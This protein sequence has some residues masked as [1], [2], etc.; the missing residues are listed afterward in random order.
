MGTSTLALGS[1]T[2]T[3]SYQENATAAGFNNTLT[4]ILSPGVYSGGGLSFVGN[5]VSLGAYDALFLSGNQTVSIHTNST[6]DLS[7]AQPTGGGLGAISSGAPYILMTFTAQTFAGNYPEYSFSASLPASP[8]Y[9]VLGKG[10]FSG[11]LIGFDYSN[12]TYPPTYN[13]TTD[14]FNIRGLTDSTTNV[15]GAMVVQGGVGIIK[16]L[17]VGPT[18]TNILNALPPVGSII[19][20]N[21]CYYTS[22]TNTGYTNVAQTLPTC[23]QL[24]NGAAYNNASSPIYNGAGRHLPNLSDNRFLM[25]YTSPSTGAGGQNSTTIASANLPTHT[26]TIPQ[27]ITGS[28]S[29]QHYHNTNSGDSRAPWGHDTSAA[30]NL[31]TAAGSGNLNAAL[32]STENDG[33]GTVAAHYHTTNAGYSTGNGA[34]ANT[35]IENRPLYLSTVYIQRVF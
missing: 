35:A 26:H 33:N 15:T 25:G 17:T 3:H 10:V 18:S 1:P 13:P 29:A 30:Y 23:W 28:Q 2:I 21:S 5:N 9:I 14:T 11:T 8:A 32:T 6:I 22:G 12:A 27:M 7:G 24:C 16:Q 19:A 34:F 20:Y 31:N 4:N